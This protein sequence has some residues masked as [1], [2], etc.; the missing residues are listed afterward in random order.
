MGIVLPILEEVRG[1]LLQRKFVFSIP[2][3]MLGVLKERFRRLFP[4]LLGDRLDELLI[5]ELRLIEIHAELRIQVGVQILRPAFVYANHGRALAPSD[6]SLLDVQIRPA[7]VDL[8]F[9]VYAS[10]LHPA[11]LPLSF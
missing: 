10:F 4:E 3:G 8:V 7:G 5:N 2:G 11:I 6:E 9:L 1:Q